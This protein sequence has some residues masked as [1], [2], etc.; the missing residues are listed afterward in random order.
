MET[1]SSKETKIGKEGGQNEE[2]EDEEEV[3]PAFSLEAT[4]TPD[5]KCI[6]KK[7]KESE[8]DKPLETDADKNVEEKEKP[9]EESHEMTSGKSGGQDMSAEDNADHS[10]VKADAKSAE[11][12]YSSIAEAND[13]HPSCTSKGS[14]PESSASLLNKP[15]P[16]GDK[17]TG[18]ASP[19][20]KTVAAVATAKASTGAAAVVA[21]KPSAPEVAEPVPAAVPAPPTK[22]VPLK[23]SPLKR[24]FDIA[25]L[26]GSADCKAGS[27]DPED[28]AAIPS[29]FRTVAQPSSSE[30]IAG[31][32][33]SA[34]AVATPQ[35]IGSRVP[36]IAENS[37]HRIVEEEGEDTVKSAFTK[38]TKTKGTGGTQLLGR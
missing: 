8:N 28:T 13:V 37:A 32:G 5:Q 10:H 36:G 16:D 9:T 27:Q 24:S 22:D 35:L 19:E 18:K 23:K 25:F 15:L 1:I 4:A 7:G 31:P 26:T 11:K 38:Y 29:P 3:A 12:A 30:L 20:K 34:S 6:D 14:N 21:V 17:E 2:K 33:S